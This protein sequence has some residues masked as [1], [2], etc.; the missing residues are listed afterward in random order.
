MTGVRITQRSITSTA[1][2]GLQANLA[3]MQR[4]Q[5]KLSSGKEIS[6]PSD[7]PV[8]AVAS[9]AYRADTARLEQYSRNATDGLGWLGTADNTLTSLS[10]SLN[11]IRDLAVSAQNASMSDGARQAIALEVGQLR[12]SILSLANTTYLDR[13]LFAGTA[14]VTAAYDAAGTYQGDPGVAVRSAAGGA[15][16]RVQVNVVGTD[17]FGD[18]ATGLFA[19]LDKLAG[20][21]AGNAGVGADIDA[22]DVHMSAVRNQQSIVGARYNRLDGMR[23]AADDQALDVKN[24]LSTVEDVDLPKTLVALQA[25]QVAYQAALGA[26]SKAIQPSLV[27]FLR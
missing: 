1:L 23:Q 10:T 21:I 4:L 24:S 16:G 27:D 8:G 6:K 17:V 13:P 25:Q 20:D 12:E 5:G 2:V 22:L 9:L 19:T 11:R 7:D 18:G 14:N 26:T 15:N 3:A